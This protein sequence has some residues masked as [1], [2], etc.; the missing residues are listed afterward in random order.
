MINFNFNLSEEDADTLLRIIHDE[1]VRF[2]STEKCEYIEKIFLSKDE[3]EKRQL[4]AEKQW[5]I[6][7]GKYVEEIFV[8]VENSRKVIDE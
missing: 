6:D 5:C 7:H 3:N 8:K 1:H 2:S 4:E